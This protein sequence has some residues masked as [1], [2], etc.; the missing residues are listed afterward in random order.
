MLNTYLLRWNAENVPFTEQWWNPPFFFPMRGALAL[1]E[2]LAGLAVIGSPVQLLGGGAVLAYNI[3]FLASFALS[4]WFAFLLVRRL[5][6]ST[7]AAFCG[8]MAYGF[9]PFRA[10]QLAH[11]QVLTSQWFPLLLLAMHGYLEDGRRRWLALAAVAWLLQGLSNGYYLLFGPVLIGLWL[12]WFPRWRSEP[13]RGLALAT[14]LGAASLLFVP[15]LLEY[16]AVHTALGLGRRAAEITRFSAHPASFVN[17]APQLAFWEPR[18][19]H[20][21]EGFLFPGVT[22]VLL[23]FGAGALSMRHAGWRTAV[24]RRSAFLFYAGAALFLA[25]LTFGPGDPAAAASRWIRPYSWLML[26]PGYDGLRVPLRFAMLS[27]LCAAVAGGLAASRLQKGP[28]LAA[29]V[30]AALAL[31]G[32]LEP[33]PLVPPPGRQLLTGVP[34]DAAILE[35]PADDT[36]VSVTAMYRALAH[37]RP[38]VNGYSGHIPVHFSILNASMRRGDPSAILE[39]ARGRPLA[40]MINDRNDPGGRFR[41]LV[42]SLPDVARLGV[43]TAGATYVVRAQPRE[44]VAAGGTVLASAQMTLPRA[45]VQLDL[46]R[47]VVVRTIAFPLRRNYLRL[48]ERVEVEASDDGKTWRT[49]WL[50]WTGG[51]ALAGALEDALL[52]PVRIPLPDVTARFLRIHPAPAWM[53][54]ELQILGP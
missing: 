17:P 31:D 18:D 29:A 38:L 44:R 3:C 11:L 6:G 51:R 28:L 7:A 10:G 41:A 52:V 42:E 5:T 26:L 34:A 48:G 46:H 13:R 14:T 36:L 40:I 35:L 4:A 39:L 1:S 19:L 22:V 27:T 2:H 8:G 54:D 50:D 47:P 12:A 49:V 43:G 25:A 15:I 23:I 53:L 30:V 24:Q 45:H 32:W 37:G 16:R 21:G 33:L 20:A 9:A